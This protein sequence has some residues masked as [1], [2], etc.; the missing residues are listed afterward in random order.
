MI[1]NTK[2]TKNHTVTMYATLG[3]KVNKTNADECYWY[4]TSAEALKRAN[5]GDTLYFVTFNK[6]ASI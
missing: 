4:T 3:S 1:K 6:V 2:T 5:D